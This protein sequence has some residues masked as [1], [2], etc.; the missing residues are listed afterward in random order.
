M[1]YIMNEYREIPSKSEEVPVKDEITSEIATVRNDKQAIK[2]WRGRNEN[3][4]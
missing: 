4:N 3:C 2:Q 1:K